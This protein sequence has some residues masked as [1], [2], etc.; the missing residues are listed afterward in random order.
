MTN[1]KECHT[2][3]RIAV[4]VSGFGWLSGMILYYARKYFIEVK[5]F[6]EFKTTKVYEDIVKNG[7]RT[8]EG[9]VVVLPL[10]TR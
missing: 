7:P 8:D 2:C 9:E 5:D 3:K 1:V 4:G 6:E 10:K